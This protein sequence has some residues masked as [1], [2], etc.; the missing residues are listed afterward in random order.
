MTTLRVAAHGPNLAAHI[1][2]LEA[3]PRQLAKRLPIARENRRH[4]AVRRVFDFVA[5]GRI[6]MSHGITRLIVFEAER[7]LYRPL[8]ARSTGD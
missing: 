4:R 8:A 6:E 2:E 7:N 1:D 5:I 3:I